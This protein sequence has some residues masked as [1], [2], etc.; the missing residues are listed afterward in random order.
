MNKHSLAGTAWVVLAVFT[1][2]SVSAC[3]GAVSP[4]AWQQDSG[5]ATDDAARADSAINVVDSGLA[6]VGSKDTGLRDTGRPDT[7]EDATVFEDA[8]GFEVPDVT[9]VEGV[10]APPPPDGGSRVPVNHRPND[11]ECVAAAP[12]GDCNANGGGPPGQMCTMDSQCTMG[13]EGRCNTDGPLPGCL[14]T[15]DTCTDDS[16][17]SAN[18]LCVCHGSAYTYG[19]GNTCMPGNCRV[20]SDCGA[21]GY[22]SP[23][24]SGGCGQVSGY[25]CHTPGDQCVNDSDCGGA[26]DACTYSTANGIWQCTMEELCG[27]HV[28]P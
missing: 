21:G 17:C 26:G 11:A 22:C 28:G 27:F 19:E 8:S 6:D 7:G 5:A 4:A 9:G 25:Y 12:P 2:S 24:A 20:D 18:E 1:L 23:T 15:Y 16:S 14:C 10:D 13:T 3:G